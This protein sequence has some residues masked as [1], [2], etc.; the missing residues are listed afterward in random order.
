[1]RS[2]LV[3]AG[4]ALLALLGWA[5]APSSQP[6]GLQAAEKKAAT[7]SKEGVAFLQAHC[8]SCH[9]ARVK[10][11]D[12]VLHRITDEAALLKDRKLF[13]TVLKVLESGEMPP[14]PRPRPAL[15]EVEMFTASVRAVFARAD[16]NAR[17][18]PGRVTIRRLNRAEY[19]N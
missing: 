9:G 12:V 15:A 10:R 2:L 19:N 8:V 14:K 11:A 4:L 16:A 17:P 13:V 7:F 3:L 5:F 6:T 1:M 18:D